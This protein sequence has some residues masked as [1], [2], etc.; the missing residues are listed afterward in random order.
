MRELCFIIK[1]LKSSK[2]QINSLACKNDDEPLKQIIIACIMSL[3]TFFEGLKKLMKKYEVK[4][5]FGP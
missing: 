5:N 4:H 3:S 1:Q 2:D